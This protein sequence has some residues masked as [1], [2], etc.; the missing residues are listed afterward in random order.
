MFSVSLVVPLL[1]QYYRNAGISSASQRELLSS[2][3]STSQ[4][5]GGLFI[6]YLSDTRILSQNHVL[7]L[8][9]VGSAISYGILGYGKTLGVKTLI[10][11]RM[12]VGLVK[13]TM[14]VSMSILVNYTTKEERASKIGR[15]NAC[16]TV[17]WII[18]PSVGAFL[19]KHVHTSAPALLACS[20]FG[21]NFT[22]AVIF[23]PKSSN[24]STDTKTRGIGASTD[25]NT[26]NDKLKSKGLSKFSSF[27][28]NIQSCFSS[29]ILGSTIFST[30]I[31]TWVR[32]ATSYQSMASYYEQMYNLEPHQRGYLTSYTSILTFIA[33]S[34]L[35]HPILKFLGGRDKKGSSEESETDD[36]SGGGERKAVYTGAL[37][38]SIVTF[39]E[40]NASLPLFLTI[41]SPLIAISGA[42]IDLSL[43][44]LVTLITP[45]SSINSVLAALDVLQNAAAVT[46]P[47]YRA[48]LFQ[49]LA[50]VH[51]GENGEDDQG[52]LMTGDPCP[53]KWLISSSAH[54]FISA[55]L[56]YLFLKE[57]RKESSSSEENKKKKE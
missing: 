11:S 33:Q 29:P 3:F 39:V 17:A 38:L 49:I 27:S 6:G 50:K 34:L 36:Y 2:I 12:L 21:L 44:S 43:R 41:L 54:W 48:A 9:F 25:K 42:L 24:A 5:V 45:K 18:G 47:F 23:L 40:L 1:H 22:I 8:S 55:L 52:S 31:F 26:T 10:C 37:V 14:T 4:I 51:V 19:Y 15:L 20:L 28:S 57:K 46:V 32:R 16:A 35:I 56:M 30:L 13:Q 53:R 7:L